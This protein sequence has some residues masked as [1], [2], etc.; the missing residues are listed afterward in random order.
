M[1]VVCTQP[2]TIDAPIQR[3]YLIFGNL[4]LLDSSLYAWYHSEDCDLNGELAAG[5]ASRPRVSERGKKQR[6]CAFGGA[7]EV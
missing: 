1:G 3:N 2:Y 6:L 7:C 4:M 5:A